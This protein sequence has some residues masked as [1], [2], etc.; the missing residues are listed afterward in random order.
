MLIFLNV[1]EYVDFVDSALL[2]LL[3]LFEASDLNNL[4]CV[5]L[6]VV[7]VNSPIDLAVGT[8]TNNLIECVILDYSHHHNSLI[9]LNNQRIS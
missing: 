4:D 2:Q 9:L 8:F 5:L 3:V 1:G 6:I 7:L